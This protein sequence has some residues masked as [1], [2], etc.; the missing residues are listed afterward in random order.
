VDIDCSI[1]E[2]SLSEGAFVINVLT[3]VSISVASA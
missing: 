3:P 1:E 2:I